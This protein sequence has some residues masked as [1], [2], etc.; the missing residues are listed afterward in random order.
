[1]LLASVLLYLIP[2]VIG[3]SLENNIAKCCGES[4]VARVE[5]NSTLTCVESP[6]SRLQVLSKT[7]NLLENDGFGKCID[8]EDGNFYRYTV[9]NS[10]LE[11]KEPLSERV[12]PKC[13]P[14]KHIYD[15]NTRSCRPGEDVAESYIMT[16]LVKIGL[17]H[18]EVITDLTFKSYGEAWSYAYKFKQGDYCFDTDLFNNFVVREC[19]GLHICEKKRC[20]RKC[21]PDGQSYVQGSYCRDT[22]VHG[23]KLN[24]TSYSEY[25]NDIDG[26]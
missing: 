16:Q 24:G 14:L 11:S 26:K 19:K 6:K 10:T 12:F 1:M 8:V 15:N 23:L 5:D 2:C 9:N 7:N 4:F 18:C 22:Y 21:C 3:Q 20:F 13:C 17:R 25:I